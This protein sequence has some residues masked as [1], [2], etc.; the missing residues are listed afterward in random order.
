LEEITVHP[1]AMI[2]LEFQHTH[3]PLLWTYT[4]YTNTQ[5]CTHTKHSIFRICSWF[6]A[7]TWI[8]SLHLSLYHPEKHWLLSKNNLS[9]SHSF[10]LP[11]FSFLYLHDFNASLLQNPKQFIFLPTTSK[12]HFIVQ[13]SYKHL[14]ISGHL[15]L[16]GRVCP[17]IYFFNY[18]HSKNT[19]TILN[20]AVQW[21]QILFMFRFSPIPS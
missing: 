4:L 20:Q 8:S 12:A 17:F 11:P 2:S 5:R 6:Q 1:C 13:N 10:S 14:F 21:V 9:F 15:P 18:C 7:C 3:T 19:P 16:Q